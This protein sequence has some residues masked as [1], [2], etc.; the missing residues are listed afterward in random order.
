MNINQERD[1]KGVGQIVEAI[2][3]SAGATTLGLIAQEVAANHN[4]LAGT[5]TVAAVGIGYTAI[6]YAFSREK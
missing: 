5:G 1:D 4:V 3:V 2:T 6:K